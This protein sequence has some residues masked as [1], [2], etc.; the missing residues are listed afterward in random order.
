M[1]GTDPIVA[2]LQAGPGS[3]PIQAGDDPIEAGD[4]PIEAGDDPIENLIV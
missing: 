2:P 1:R 3:D 4:D